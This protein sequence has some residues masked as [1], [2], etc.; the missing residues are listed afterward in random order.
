MRAFNWKR[1]GRGVAIL[2]AALVAIAPV[3]IAKA[4]GG[5][6]AAFD[7][8]DCFAPYDGCCAC[9]AASLP[10]FAC[11]KNA[12]FGYYLCE[13][14]GSAGYGRCGGWGCGL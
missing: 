2:A 14:G 1:C 8:I 13:H 11:Y 4:L 3:G 5:S 10:D 7:D 12:I 6:T 9:Y